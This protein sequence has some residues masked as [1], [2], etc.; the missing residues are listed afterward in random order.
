[1]WEANCLIHVEE[2]RTDLPVGAQVAI[3]W[4][5]GAP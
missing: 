2:V 5:P 3:Q 4:L 1:M